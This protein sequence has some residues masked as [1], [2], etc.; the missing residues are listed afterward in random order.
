MTNASA[1]LRLSDDGKSQPCPFTQIDPK[2][3]GSKEELLSKGPQTGL[4]ILSQRALTRTDPDKSTA[5]ASQLRLICGFE[6]HQNLIDSRLQA[7]LFHLRS[8]WYLK[9]CMQKHP[10]AATLNSHKYQDLLTTLHQI[11]ST[12][13]Q[14]P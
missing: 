13:K 10:N 2:H 14:G 6:T 5:V 3:H 4:S 1:T 11:L 9:T 8:H 7:M 12:I